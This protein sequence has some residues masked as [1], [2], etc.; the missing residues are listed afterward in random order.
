MSEDSEALARRSWE[1]VSQC[2]PDALE[3]AYAADSVLHE[4]DQDL[5]GLEEVKQY[6]S[7]YVSAF[8]DLNAMP[9]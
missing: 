3:E 8:P 1:I 9:A 7:M 6:L 5:Q 2:N 4:P